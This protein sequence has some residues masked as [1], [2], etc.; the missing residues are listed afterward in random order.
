MHIQTIW[1]CDANGNPKEVFL[2]SSENYYWRVRIYDGNGQPVAGASVTSRLYRPGNYPNTVWATSTATTDATGVAAF[3]RT[4]KSN[5]LVG[6]Y[7]T[8]VSA[9]TKSGMTYDPG[10]NLQN[11][12]TFQV[13]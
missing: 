7:T 6:T 11:T 3:S 9:V 10:A 2:K 12:D 4:H 8:D 1:S 5:D 13:Q